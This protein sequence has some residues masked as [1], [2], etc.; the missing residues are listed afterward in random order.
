MV[1][2]RRRKRHVRGAKEIQS[3]VWAILA[4]FAAVVAFTGG[5]SRYDAIQIIPLRF[6]SAFFLTVSLLFLT[7]EKLKHDRSLLILFGCLV[8]IVAIQLVPLP[9]SI[10]QSLPD[11]AD[12][13]RSDDALTLEGLWRPL[14]LAP[15]RTWNVLGSLVVPAAGLFLAIALRAPSTML[16][17]IIAA[18]GVLNAVFGLLQIA[19]G[20]GSVLYLYE[21]TNRGS[22]VGIFANGN[23]S[24]VFSAFSMLLMTFLGLKAR[25]SM[26]SFW[27]KLVYI[28]AFSLIFCVSMVGGSRAGFV[29][30][31]GAALVS[32]AMLMLSSGRLERRSGDGLL[33]RWLDKYPRSVLAIPVIAVLLTVVSFV[34]LDR[35]PAIRVILSQDALDD[36]R[37]SLL[38]V[39]SEMLSGHWALGTGFGSFER[40]YQIY[41]PSVLLMPSYVN[42]AHN[43]WAQFLIEGGVLS[44]VILIGL[45]IWIVRAV[46]TLSLDRNRKIDAVFWISAFAVI[47][48]ASLVDYP[49]R[50]PIFQLVAV[51]LLLALSR[52][53]RDA[54]MT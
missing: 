8:L 29:A 49:L 41:E 50:T 23:H 37:W 36:L 46:G 1:G 34:A 4:V 38:P 14:T 48:A 3:R 5:A 20:R 26:G 24:A 47:A 51:W 12:I 9:P 27:E 10:W 15:L 40:V 30:A 33:Y 39:M 31:V 35:V 32:L 19:T 28:A 2:S 6:L 25:H 44:A 54:R 43:D 45:L 22:L 7:R 52:D 18:M 17:R 16:L 11:R 21:V 53:A 42:Q 13:L